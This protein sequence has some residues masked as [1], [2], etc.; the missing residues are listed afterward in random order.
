LFTFAYM[1]LLAYAAA[2]VVYQVG[3]LL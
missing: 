2:F 3:S 1:T